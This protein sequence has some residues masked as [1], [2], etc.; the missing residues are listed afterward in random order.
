LVVTAVPALLVGARGQARA[1]GFSADGA[2]SAVAQAGADLMAAGDVPGGCRKLRQATLLDASATRFLALGECWERAGNTASSWNAYHRAEELAES[3]E[4]DIDARA[5]EGAARVEALL[6]RLEITLP[7]G[8]EFADVEVYLDG[9]LLSPLL[10]GV[11][12]PVDP[13]PHELSTSA[14][15]RQRFALELSLPNGP[16]TTRVRIPESSLARKPI[17]APPAK[18]PVPATEDAS[19][20]PSGQALRIVGLALGGIGVASLAVGTGFAIKAGHERAELDAACPNG[21]CNAAEKDKFEAY[22]HHSTVASAALVT[23]VVSLAGGVIVYLVA[24]SAHPA[25]S[26]PVALE[27]LVGPGLAGLSAHGAF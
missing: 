26:K 11:A 22:D 9:S 7:S 24:P 20:P 4:T 21:V 10:Y 12:V 8:A 25:K 2:A 17:T 14:L 13:G 19:E 6:C 16:G 3:G 5:R 27:P 1:E 15:G 23:G 18:A